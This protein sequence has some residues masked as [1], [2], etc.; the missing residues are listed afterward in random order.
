MAGGAAELPKWQTKYSRF[1]LLTIQV[2]T[3]EYRYT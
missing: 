2:R 1:F 3:V